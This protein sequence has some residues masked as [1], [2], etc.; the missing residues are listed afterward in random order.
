MSTKPDPMA[1]ARAWAKEN[2]LTAKDSGVIDALRHAA[3][4]RKNLEFL[5]GNV[6]SYLRCLDGVMKLPESQERGERIALMANGLE[7]VNDRVRYIT[8]G[9]D[10]RKDAPAPTA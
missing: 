1:R 9:E 2:P 7:M 5:T 10:W 3:Q 6:R 8:L 4:L